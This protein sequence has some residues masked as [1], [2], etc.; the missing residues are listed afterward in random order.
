[1]Q[2]VWKVFAYDKHVC[3]YRETWQMFKFLE[4]G[5]DGSWLVKFEIILKN[6]L[7]IKSIWLGCEGYEAAQ[8]MLQ[9]VKYEFIQL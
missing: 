6:L 9:Y 2:C 1:M 3:I 4:Q 5:A 7:W 8:T